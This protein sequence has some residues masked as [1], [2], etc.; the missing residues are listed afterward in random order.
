MPIFNITASSRVGCVRAH[1]EDMVLVG[2]QVIRDGE[3]SLSVSVDDIDRLVVAVADGMGGHRSG[4]VASSD[5]IENLRYFFSDLPVGLS[6][7]Q[8]REFIVNWHASIHSILDSKGRADERYAKM[9]TTLVALVGYAHNYYWLN[10]GDSRLYRLHQG[11]FTQVTT[12]HSLANEL[13]GNTPTNIITNCIGGGCRSS[14]IDMVQCN[15]LIQPGDVLL[16]CSDGLSDLLPD[17]K[18]SQMLQQGSNATDLCLA[19]EAAG[20]YDNVSVVVI[21]IE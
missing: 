18:I 5:T 7:E 3:T 20:G 12:D 15:D 9:G 13:G 17:D 10:C 11:E 14:F 16:L 19:A 2:D 8:F 1:N 4:D 6:D 21:K